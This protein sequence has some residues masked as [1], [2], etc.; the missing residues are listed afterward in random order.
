MDQ[1]KKN[2]FWI[3]LGVVVLGALGAWFSY[4]PDLDKAK[5]DALARAPDLHKAVDA[6]KRP[7]GLKTPAHKKAVDTLV[8]KLDSE[9][10]ELIKTLEKWPDFSAKNLNSRY[11]DAPLA[12]RNI[13][14]DNWMEAQRKRL[15]KRLASATVAPP[16]DFDT[17]LFFGVNIDPAL[18]NKPVDLNSKASIRHR[19]FQ[20][21]ILSIVDD[22]VEAL[23]SQKDNLQVTKFETDPAKPETTE[24]IK[25][26]PVALASFTFHGP[27]ETTKADSKGYDN[28]LARSGWKPPSVTGPNVPAGYQGQHLPYYVTSVDVEFVSHISAVPPILRKLENGEKYF[29]VLTKADCERAAAPYPGALTEPKTQQDF[30]KAAPNPSINTHFNEAPVKAF[31]T[32]E[33]YEFDKTKAE[34]PPVTA[35]ARPRTPPPAH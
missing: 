29:A 31:A 7:D 33:F 5:S 20:L 30:A 11:S 26:G 1:L 18:S 16:A 13:E 34:A 32:L 25:I 35:P 14:F 8:S 19:D 28:A 4:M 17:K 6:S 12:T 24:N 10:K 22:I 9:K 23:V 27:D 15:N 21:R 2:L 3:I